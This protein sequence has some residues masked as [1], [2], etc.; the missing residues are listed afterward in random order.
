MTAFDFADSP[1]EI[2]SDLVAA[3]VRTWKALAEPGAWW[4]GAQR[5]ALAAE[6]RAARDCPLCAERKQALSPYSVEGQHDGSESHLPEAAVDA[7][8]R[9]VTDPTRLSQSYVEKLA[10]NG[11]SDGHYVEL[12]GVVV[13][14]VSIDSFHRALGMP[15]EPLPAAQGG[16][17]S[18]QRPVSAVADV[19]WVP[20]IP[21][22]EA[23]GDEADLYSAKAP[24]VLRAMSL[25]PDAVRC[26]RDLSTAQ[27]IP[28]DQLADPSADPG[29]ALS[30]SQ[31][32]L[33]A[34]RVSAVNECFY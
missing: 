32:E 12:L 5:V 29:R 8:H 11:L 26:M 16:A 13:S 30:R 20:M 10:A 9:M 24:N 2:R 15:L 34:G 7:V 31:I 18:G 17:P 14:I 1:F 23:R 28:L 4:T 21:Q 19:G 33:V 25:V 3:Y 6:S 27:Y 22:G